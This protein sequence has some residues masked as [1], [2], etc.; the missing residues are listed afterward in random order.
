MRRGADK[1]GLFKAC[2]AK[3]HRNFNRR[4]Y[5]FGS[6]AANK[7]ECEKMAT[8]DQKRKTAQQKNG[9]PTSNMLGN[10]VLADAGNLQSD[11]P[12][13]NFEASNKVQDKDDPQ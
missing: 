10:F 11:A 5:V 2:R 7:K 3:R 8:N 12:L 1:C 6:L 4:A 13:G 9:A